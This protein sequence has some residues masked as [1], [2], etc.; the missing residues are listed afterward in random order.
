MHAYRYCIPGQPL[1]KPQVIPTCQLNQSEG[2]G[3]AH[4]RAAYRYGVPLTVPSLTSI[5][6][7]CHESHDRQRGPAPRQAPMYGSLYYARPV[8]PTIWSHFFWPYSP[9]SQ[10]LQNEPGRC[11]LKRWFSIS[12]PPQRLT[13]TYEH[14]VFLMKAD[15]T[16]TARRQQQNADCHGGDVAERGAADERLWG[17]ASLTS[18]SK[19]AH[20]GMP[21]GHTTRLV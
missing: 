19:C 6:R 5:I 3:R 20:Q 21:S 16:G 15:Y 4:D 8:T 10:K 12:Q 13:T 14:G 7:L 2:H 9:D 17:R 18:D 1:I 11:A